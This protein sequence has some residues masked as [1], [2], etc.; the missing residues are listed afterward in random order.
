MMEMRPATHN[1]IVGLLGAIEDDKIAEIEAIGATRAQLG[2][3]A[4]WLAQK[5]PVRED[6]RKPLI[7]TA[8]EVYKIVAGDGKLPE[9][10]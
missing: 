10:H 3:V 6:P 8:A 9:D 2:E 1:E 4:A 5:S 7:G